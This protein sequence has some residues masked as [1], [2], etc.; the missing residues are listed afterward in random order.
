MKVHGPYEWHKSFIFY[1]YCNSCNR[2]FAL[3]FGER[4]DEKFGLFITESYH[5][6]ECT[7]KLNKICSK[8]D[9]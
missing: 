3:E 2:W 5:C 4:K 6:R 8:Y 7:K 1:G 9:G